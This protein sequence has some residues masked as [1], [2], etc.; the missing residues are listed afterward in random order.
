MIIFFDDISIPWMLGLLK[1]AMK[2]L[3]IFSDPTN[4]PHLP[5]P[6]NFFHPHVDVAS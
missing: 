4:F 2:C 3:S 5:L 1:I 6:I